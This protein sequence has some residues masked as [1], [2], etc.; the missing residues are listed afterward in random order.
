MDN[1]ST[2]EGDTRLGIT[3]EG[4]I[5]THTER[6]GAPGERSGHTNRPALDKH[7][8]FIIIWAMRLQLNVG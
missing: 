8:I 2:G 1:V 6:V 5:M 7:F 4:D 3:R